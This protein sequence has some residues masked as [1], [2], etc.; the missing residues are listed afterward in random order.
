[1]TPDLVGTIPQWI[2]AISS[3]SVAAAVVALVTAYW[4]RGVSLKTLANADHA[5]I[6]DH[7]ADE[8]ERVVARQH[9]CE[10]R[11]H[12]LRNRVTELENDVLALIR[13][14]GQAGTNKVLQLGP[15][16]SE[17][18]RGMTERVI[19]RSSVGEEE[20]RLLQEIDRKDHK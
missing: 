1:V 13:I 16:V 2:T 11:E 12:I 10:E 7:Y 5:D 18:I 19:A 14:I 15:D 17:T 6:R 4:K 20:R 9:E 8:L 3:T